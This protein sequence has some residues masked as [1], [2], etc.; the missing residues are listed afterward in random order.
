M[1]ATPSP[2]LGG[3]ADGVSFLF[4]VAHTNAGGS[5]INVGGKGVRT[6]VRTDGSA[7]QAGDLP[8]SG[9]ALATSLGSQVVLLNVLQTVSGVPVATTV[10]N[11]VS[12]EATNTEMTN[13]AT[14]GSNPEF[15][16]PEGLPLY[17]EPKWTAV[18]RTGSG[19]ETKANEVI[20]LRGAANF[21]TTIVSAAGIAQAS[22]RTETSRRKP[23]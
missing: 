9:I 1:F 6:L 22:R 21:T 15:V 16:T 7:L 23:A 5:T 12:R 2:S 17:A 13:G 8:A 11:G 18:T 4:N 14:T 19:T 20:I 10:A 3:Y